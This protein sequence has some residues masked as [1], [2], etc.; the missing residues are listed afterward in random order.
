[1]LIKPR[2][3]ALAVVVLMSA[4]VPGAAQAGIWGWGCTSKPGPGQ[5]IF[6]RYSLLLFADKP[7]RLTLDAIA[8]STEDL[9]DDAS[10]AGFDPAE[11]DADTGDAFQPTMPFVAS[12]DAKQKLV[13]TE[14]SSRQ[15][16]TRTRRV[17]LR[18]ETRTVWKKVYRL[19]Q[20]G[21][22]ARDIAMDCMEYNLST[23]GG[24]S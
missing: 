19:E 22:P 3:A 7:T 15:V 10:T 24:R 23:K 4:A 20:G 16:S 14:K 17:A 9:K 18:D 8:T 2:L 1:M 11:R 21:E 13:L 6:S 12:G 5:V